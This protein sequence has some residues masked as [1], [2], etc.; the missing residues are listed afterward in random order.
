MKVYF[1]ASL[2]GKVKYQKEFEVI[3]KTMRNLGHEVYAKHVMERDYEKV[4]KQ[5]KKQ[6]EADFQRMRDGIR[7][8]DVVVI[9][10]TYPS[11]GVGHM[12]TIALEMYKPVLLLYQ[13]T[14]HGLLIGDPNRLLIIK[15][16]SLNNQKKLYH[17]I[18]LFLRKSERKLLRKRFN[19]MIDKGQ[20]EYLDWIAKSQ[21][22]SKANFIRRLIDENIQK[23]KKY[24]R[25]KAYG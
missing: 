20:E 22:I 6:H 24:S 7:K 11:V 21:A 23:D 17:I 19:L 25:I 12:I 15:K 2:L 8:S 1:N 4:N 10:A 14:P 16:Y 18:D 13:T 9:E 3:I 5:T